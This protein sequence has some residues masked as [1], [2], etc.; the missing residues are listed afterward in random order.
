MGTI[1][2]WSLVAKLNSAPGGSRIFDKGWHALFVKSVK[3]GESTPEG[4]IALF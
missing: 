2:L 3:D 4:V 1:K